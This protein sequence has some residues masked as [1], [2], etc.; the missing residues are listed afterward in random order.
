MIMPLD[1]RDD[2][3]LEL[4]RV[5]AESMLAR[6]MDMVFHC[7]TDE[8]GED[9]E[10]NASPEASDPAVQVFFLWITFSMSRL[11]TVNPQMQVL[12]K[13]CRGL[14]LRRC[15]G[16]MRSRCRRV[17]WLCEEGYLCSISLV[18]VAW[19]AERACTR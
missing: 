12:V 11:L 2:F 15:G 18:C 4:A 8:E 5:E 16:Q 1:V 9:D 10:E 3:A 17:A 6:P 13:I 19:E 7:Q 14:V